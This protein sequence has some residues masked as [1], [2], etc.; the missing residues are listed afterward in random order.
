MRGANITRAT[1]SEGVVDAAEDR[2]LAAT[3]AHIDVTHDIWGSHAAKPEPDGG[4]HVGPRVAPAVGEHLAG[5][6]ERRGLQTHASAERV[7]AGDAGAQLRAG[8]DPVLVYV[9]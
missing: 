9:A 2:H 1:G 3:V 5:V 7:E 8:G 4:V 6:D